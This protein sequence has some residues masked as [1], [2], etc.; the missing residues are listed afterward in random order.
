MA[1]SSHMCGI[2]ITLI[3]CNMTVLR[4]NIM[5]NFYGGN[6]D[7]LETF[8]LNRQNLTRQLFKNNTAFTGVW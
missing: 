8:Q 7:V 2:A 4:N 1:S 3:F 5:Q 6:F